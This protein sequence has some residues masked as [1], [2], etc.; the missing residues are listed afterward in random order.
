MPMR[1]ARKGNEMTTKAQE[2]KA[3]EQ[4]RKIV[5]DLGDDS[6]VATA[7]EG[8]FDIAEQN[9]ELDM[10]CSMKGRWEYSEKEREAMAETINR[11]RTAAIASG[12]RIDELEAM[13]NDLRAERNQAMN[14]AMDERKDITI[15]MTDGQRECKAFAKVAYFDNDGFRFITVVEKSGWTTSY[16]IDDLKT[17]CIE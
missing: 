17:L 15:E 14:N 9:I 3:L 5:A 7:F 10:A 1:Q 8:C 2:R 13:V 4:I 6:Y 12:K 11:M 16:K